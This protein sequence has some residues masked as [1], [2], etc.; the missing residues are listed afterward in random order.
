MCLN[1]IFCLYFVYFLSLKQLINL[2]SSFIQDSCCSSHLMP[3]API[4]NCQLFFPLFSD[5][6]FYCLLS[7]SFLHLLSVRF[8]MNIGK[9]A[10][11]LVATPGGF[12][13][14]QSQRP[15]SLVCGRITNL[16][17]PSVSGVLPTDKIISVGFYHNSIPSLHI[18]TKCNLLSH[19]LPPNSDDTQPNQEFVSLFV[20][21]CW[22]S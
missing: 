18:Y 20:S 9:F 5:Y 10:Q 13:F 12:C 14:D 15:A 21:T 17:C 6:K 3:Y 2:A 11:V 4:I 16:A 22:S 8:K 19:L 1:N 7:T